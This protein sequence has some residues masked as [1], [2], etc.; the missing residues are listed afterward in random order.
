MS[1]WD[2]AI[3]LRH[4]SWLNVQCNRRF[5][6]LA[7]RY[8]EKKGSQGIAMSL[9]LS[10]IKSNSTKFEAGAWKLVTCFCVAAADDDDDGGG[11]N[12]HPKV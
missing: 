2:N 5:S 1:E 4:Y 3:K 10:G 8:A 9:D 6:N 11:H 12:K 7:R